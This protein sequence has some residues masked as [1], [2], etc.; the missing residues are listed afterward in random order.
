MCVEHVFGLSGRDLCSCEFEQI[1]AG[2]FCASHRE[3]NQVFT[4]AVQGVMKVL[5]QPNANKWLEAWSQWTKLKAREKRSTSV[6]QGADG[7]LTIWFNVQKVEG[8]WFV[9]SENPHHGDV[10]CSSW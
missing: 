2:R 3:K 5:P 4:Q 1:R 8:Q 9:G 7:L 10:D 6:Q